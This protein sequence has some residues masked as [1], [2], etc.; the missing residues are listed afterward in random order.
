M[1]LTLYRPDDITIVRRATGDFV[2][3]AEKVDISRTAIDPTM[4]IK[5]SARK[6]LRANWSAVYNGC[7]KELGFVVSDRITLSVFGDGDVQDTV[8]AFRPWI[9]GEVLALEV[10]VWHRRRVR[11]T[12]RTILT[13]MVG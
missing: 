12:R 13:S 2:V 9:A 7:A 3:K 4:T 6:G 1:N 10:H 11:I 5:R 8:T